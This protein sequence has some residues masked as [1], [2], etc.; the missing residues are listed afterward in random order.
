MTPSA[1]V[2]AA[3][4]MEKYSNTG[5][6]MFNPETNLCTPGGRLNKTETPPSNPEGALYVSLKPAPPLRIMSYGNTTSCVGI[7]YQNV[8]YQDATSLCRNMGYFLMSVK[9]L[10]KLMILRAFVPSLRVWLGCDDIS[11]KGNFIWQ[12]DGSSV[13]AETAAAVFGPGEPSQLY[14][15]NCCQLA[16]L[17]Q[18]LDD[19]VCHVL[20]PYVCEASVDLC[21]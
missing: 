8:S 6:F 5:S 13:T 18:K 10:D 1:V 11:S 21:A 4:S 15:R 3:R 7:F 9:T 2:C 14:T 20:L 12:E 16:V 19:T 17:T